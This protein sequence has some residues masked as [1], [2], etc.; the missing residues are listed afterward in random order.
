MRQTVLK[1][2]K[3][4][5]SVDD[6]PIIEIPGIVTLE[7][8]GGKMRNTKYFGPGDVRVLAEW[9]VHRPGIL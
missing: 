5:V 9:N 3:I 4:Y 6:M 2:L 8:M 7:G 1:Y